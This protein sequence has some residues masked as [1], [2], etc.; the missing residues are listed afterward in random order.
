MECLAD[1]QCEF[2]LASA[3]SDDTV[4]FWDA[5]SGE[6]KERLR[7]HPGGVQRLSFSHDRQRM[8]MASNDGTIKTWKFPEPK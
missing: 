5:A 6:S 1:C 8:T 7:D 3:S 4:R 2:S